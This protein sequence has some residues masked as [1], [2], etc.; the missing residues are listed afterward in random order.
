MTEKQLQTLGF[1][2]QLIHDKTN[3]L[4]YYTLEITSGLAF[5]SHPNVDVKNGEWIVEIYESE[6]IKFT[7]AKTLS[8][9]INILNQNKHEYS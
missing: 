9:L 8:T 7:D 2:K 6:D 5:I 1:E 4:Y 3:L